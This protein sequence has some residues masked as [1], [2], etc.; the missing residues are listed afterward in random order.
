MEASEG[1][2]RGRTGPGDHT[3]AA[4]EPGRSDRGSARS[5]VGDRAGALHVRGRV[6]LRTEGEPAARD[7]FEKDTATTA[8]PRVWAGQ[9]RADPREGIEGDRR[10]KA[11]P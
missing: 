6:P 5:R 8:L 9:A 4:W 1:A 2:G 10:D 7:L 11:R 3:P